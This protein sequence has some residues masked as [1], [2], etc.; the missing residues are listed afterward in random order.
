MNAPTPPQRPM[1]ARWKVQ[2][3]SEKDPHKFAAA[4]EATLQELSDGNWQ[5][6]GQVYRG[7]TLIITACRPEPVPESP[8]TEVRHPLRRAVSY[9]PKGDQYQEVLYSYAPAPGAAVVTQKCATMVEALTL[10]K[11]HLEGGDWPLPI[12]IVACSM[13][14]YEAKTI[15]AL[16]KLHAKELEHGR[17]TLG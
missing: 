4:V 15:P 3:V 7:D 16:L 6:L 14:I 9:Q 1:R 2:A 12:K 13:S 5:L 11:T 8:P 10:L 17:H